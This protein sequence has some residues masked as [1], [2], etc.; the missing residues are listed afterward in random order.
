[1]SSS[2][3][4]EIAT[5]FDSAIARSNAMRR[6]RFDDLIL[7]FLDEVRVLIAIREAYE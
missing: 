6:N 4:A 2:T 7:V 1:M 3:A 5:V